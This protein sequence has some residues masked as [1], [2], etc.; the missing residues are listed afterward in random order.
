MVW[1]QRNHLE[2]VVRLE[3]QGIVVLRAVHAARNY[4][5]LER[6]VLRRREQRLEIVDLGFRIEPPSPRLSPED[7]W[8]PMV[9]PGQVARCL[10]RDNRRRFDDLSG[11]LR[12]PVFV[13]AREGEQS[14]L[15]RVEPVWDVSR[16][17]A[18]LV[19]TVRDD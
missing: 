7:H 4:A 2:H 16:P 3:A 13:K 6:S 11:L 9:N 10:G 18:P 5:R 8:H 1:S 15:G 19:E 12:I 17:G 14:A